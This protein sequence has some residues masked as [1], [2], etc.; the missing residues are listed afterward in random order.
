M[1][2]TKP[3]FSF[4]AR[5]LHLLY[6]TSP[7]TKSQGTTTSTLVLGSSLVVTSQPKLPNFGIKLCNH[8]TIP[9]SGSILPSTRSSRMFFRSLSAGMVLHEP[10]SGGYIPDSWSPLTPPFS[11]RSPLRGS[12]RICKYQGS[13]NRLQRLISALLILSRHRCRVSYVFLF[14]CFS[15]ASRLLDFTTFEL[16][17]EGFLHNR[18]SN[19]GLLDISSK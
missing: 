7:Q 13:L 17:V 14:I 12:F 10:G 18:M 8:S 16:H 19:V 15:L 11:S 2:L 4:K 9:P 5:D 6:Q 1:N 3:T